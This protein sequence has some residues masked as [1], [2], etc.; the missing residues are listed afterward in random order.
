MSVPSNPAPHV[1]GFTL[2]ELVFS[3]VL[4]G[5][6]TALAYGAF[7]QASNSA[8]SV[9]A[10]LSGEQELRLLMKMVL[11]DLQST[12]YLKQW[13]D[14]EPREHESGLVAEQVLGPDNIE[15][16]RISFHTDRPSS[17]FQDTEEVRNGLD[18]HLHEIG[19]GLEFNTTEDVWQ[20][21]KREDYYLDPNLREGRQEGRQIVLSESVTGF[22]VEFRLR[23][24]Q[25]ASGT[26]STQEDWAG[27]WDSEEGDCT[28]PENKESFCLPRSIRVTLK[29]VG[30]DGRELEDR[31]EINLCVYPCNPEI[32]GENK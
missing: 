32:F 1:R 14:A 3:I 2:I 8:R 10:T 27:V 17:L 31:Q 30:D 12:R 29:L 24:I 21:V 18:P 25:A 20:F 26:Q 11:D 28:N 16:S 19:Y 9:Q 13:V 15:A 22:L 7:F 6:I 5:L 23:E 4:L